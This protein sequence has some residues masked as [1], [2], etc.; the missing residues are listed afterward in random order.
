MPVSFTNFSSD[1]ILLMVALLIML[2]LIK[3]AK[4][5]LHHSEK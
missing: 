1:A 3:R 4:A 5:Y 2:E